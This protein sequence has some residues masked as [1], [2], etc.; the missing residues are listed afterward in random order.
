V[1]RSV[2][3]KCFLD[4]RTPT[5]SAFYLVP[6]GDTAILRTMTFW[7]DSEHPLPWGTHGMWVMLDAAGGYVW[8]LE[9]SSMI[10]GAYHW[11]GWEVFT[12]YMEFYCEIP[13][14]N[15]RANG[16]LLTPT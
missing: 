13:V 3:S 11:T 5:P 16:T 7:N 12:G 9:A 8:S 15:F 6:V 2:Y 1:P 10:R 14:F 4:T